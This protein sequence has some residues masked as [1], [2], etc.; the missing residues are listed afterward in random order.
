MSRRGKRIAVWEMRASGEMFKVEVRMHTGDHEVSF[1]AQIPDSDV[2]VRGKDIDKLRADAQ[3]ALNT[4]KELNWEDV[5]YVSGG[6]LAKGYGAESYENVRSEHLRPETPDP[7]NSD[8]RSL[9]IKWARMQRAKAPDGEY[10]FRKDA[11][12]QVTRRFEMEYKSAQA[13]CMPWT[14]EREVALIRLTN[15][16]VM[17]GRE[18]HKAIQADDLVAKLDTNG[19]RLLGSGDA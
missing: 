16:L 2:R 9:A 15:A 10:R 18:F 19:L 3:V 17:L 5:L 8:D 4:E 13:V 7:G 14:P 11:Q 1:E 6:L 12:S